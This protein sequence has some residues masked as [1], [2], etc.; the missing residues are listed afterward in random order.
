M[1]DVLDVG[2]GRAEHAALHVHGVLLET[3]G[4]RHDV[5]REGRR[6]QVRAAL[7][8]QHREDRLEVLAKAQVEHRVGFVE[9]HGGE[10]GSVDPAALER[11]AQA[12]RCGDDHGR[13][14]RERA[15]LV[16]VARA[17]GDGHHSDAQRGVEPGQLVAHLLGELPRGRQDEHAG[18]R[19]TSEL[20]REVVEQVAH[21]EADGDR[22]ARPRLRGDAQVPPVER[23]V[24]HGLLHGGQRVVAPGCERGRER[25]ADQADERCEVGSGHGCAGLAR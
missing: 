25:R 2:V 21:G 8:R 19:G 15:L 20:S 11:V 24:E 6:D 4:E 3:I 10:R 7:L 18:L 12:T 16:E 14:R 5:A 23:L 17:A 22:L 1:H 9:H 13:V